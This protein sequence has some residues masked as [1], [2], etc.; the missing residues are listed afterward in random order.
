MSKTL[1][2]NRSELRLPDLNLIA[3][4][5]KLVIRKSSKFSPDGFLQTLLSSVV[6]GKASSHQIAADL[7]TREDASMARQSMH[8]RFT[9]KSTAF[10]LSTLGDLMKQRFDPARAALKDSKIKRIVVED[11]SGQI[12]PKSNAGEVISHILEQ[13]THP[14]PESDFVS[15]SNSSHPT[16]QSPFTPAAPV[17]RRLQSPPAKSKFL[18]IKKPQSRLPG[19]WLMI[20]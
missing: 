15:F 2:S 20:E 13:A 1:P 7:Q 6:T 19:L 12:I 10:L 14:K 3:N 18:A 5:T 4:E 16:S 8:E 9:H 17:Q 11:A